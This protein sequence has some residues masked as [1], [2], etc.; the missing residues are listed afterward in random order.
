MHSLLFGIVVFLPI[1]L[2]LHVFAL[3]FI[4]V[5]VVFFCVVVFTCV[6]FRNLYYNHI[7]FHIL[8]MLILNFA[9]Q[10]NF[11]NFLTKLIHTRKRVLMELKEEKQQ[12]HESNNN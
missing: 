7:K 10:V 3:F 2:L 8:C 9:E 1:P 12:A 4:D 11:I 6:V 5:D